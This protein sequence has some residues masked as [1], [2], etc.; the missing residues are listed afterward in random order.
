M[1]GVQ[2]FL[3]KTSEWQGFSLS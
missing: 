2:K 3:N 1:A